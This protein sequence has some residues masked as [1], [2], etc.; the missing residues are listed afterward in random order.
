MRIIGG[1][2]RRRILKTPYKQRPTL[3]FVRESLFNILQ[4]HLL[5][6]DTLKNSIILD[7]YA[8]SG[9]IGLEALS[10]GAQKAI[11]FE[12]N[13][14]V[15]QII[16]ENISLLGFIKKSKI[17][18]IN[19]IN[20]PFSE[21]PVN[22]IFLDPPYNQNLILPSLLSL[23]KRGWINCKTLISIERSIDESKVSMNNL[24]YVYYRKYRRCYIE[25]AYLRST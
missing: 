25:F 12:K 8:G 22:I 24:D 1:T 17:Y 10:R 13:Y 18:T 14:K 2:H 4:H 9:A 3:S 6:I 16:K 21:N 19:T 5:S 15:S 11:F 20:P 23:Y 7:A